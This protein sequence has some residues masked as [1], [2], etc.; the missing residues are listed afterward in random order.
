[1]KT[2]VTNRVKLSYETVEKLFHEVDASVLDKETLEYS[3]WRSR[4][5][6]PKLAQIASTSGIPPEIAADILLMRSVSIKRDN[7]N[8]RMKFMNDEITY[9]FGED[10]NPTEGLIP[11]PSSPYRKSA[12]SKTTFESNN[13]TPTQLSPLFR[14]VVHVKYPQSSSLIEQSMIAANFLVGQ[15]MQK[16]LNVSTVYRVHP[17]RELPWKDL[18]PDLRSAFEKKG[19]ELTGDKVTPEM[20]AVMKS[21]KLD[22]IRPFSQSITSLFERATYTHKNSSSTDKAKNETEEHPKDSPTLH[23][24]LNLPWYMHFTSP[25]RRFADLVVH[26]RLSHVLETNSEWS[27]EDLDSTF[28]YINEKQKAVDVSDRQRSFC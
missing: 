13:H 16:E 6:P 15:W 17:K 10:G 25:I 11:I 9:A 18:H 12:T 24:G 2:A 27:T 8:S 23:F 3:L 1:M 28:V 5:L 20:E 19:V 22:E 4:T 26:Q 7:L 21:M 14:S